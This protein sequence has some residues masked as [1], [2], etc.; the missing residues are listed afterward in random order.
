M[1]GVQAII[2]WLHGTGLRPFLARLTEA[3]RPQFLDRYAALLS[4]EYK[5]RADGK[6]LLPYPRLF[7]IA[8]RQDRQ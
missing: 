4:E 6:I 3:E 2:A 5:P 7:F 1:D 8:T